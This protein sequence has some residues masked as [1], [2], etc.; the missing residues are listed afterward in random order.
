MPRPASGNYCTVVNA[1]PP[2]ASTSP[3][4]KRSRQRDRIL[5]W[6]RESD[7]HPTAAE[8]HDALRPEIPNLS[9]GTVYRNLD[10]LVAEGEADEVACATGATRYD[11]N[12]EPH[13]H[14]TCEGCGRILDVDV[15]T[16][17]GLTRR[18]ES[19]HG[20]T[21]RRIRLAF[22][23]LCPECTDS[24]CETHASNPTIPDTQ[25]SN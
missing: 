15:P 21:A 8:I 17:R 5:A 2:N 4:R 10:V 12:V 1:S 23:G 6:L 19:D 24:T 16:P 20:L 25:K 22:F 18:L 3:R 14:F 13:H 9:L 11:G 7:Q